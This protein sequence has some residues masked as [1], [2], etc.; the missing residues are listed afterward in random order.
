MENIL[1]SVCVILASTLVC[2]HTQ[3][4]THPD[5]RLQKRPCTVKIYALNY[6]LTKFCEPGDDGLQTGFAIRSIG[7]RCDYPWSVG[8]NTLLN[9]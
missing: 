1:F 9:F 8:L 6:K 3:Y 7:D 2:T 4:Y 5:V